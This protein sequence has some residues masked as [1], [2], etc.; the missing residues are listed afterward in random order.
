MDVLIV[1]FFRGQQCTLMCLSARDIRICHF[2]NVN[3]AFSPPKCHVWRAKGGVYGLDMSYEGQR[4][5]W[6]DEANLL[7]I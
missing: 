5:S 7:Y 4:R 2:E 6:R 3:T 1:N